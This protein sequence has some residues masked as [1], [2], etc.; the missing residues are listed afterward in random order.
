M[1]IVYQVREWGGELETKAFDEVV[2]LISIVYEEVVHLQSSSAG[3]D[4]EAHDEWKKICV[5]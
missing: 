4:I 5:A 2:E 3:R 1:T